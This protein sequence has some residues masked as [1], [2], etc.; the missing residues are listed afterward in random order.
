MPG[1]F[2]SS[3]VIRKWSNH[4]LVEIGWMDIGLRLQCVNTFMDNLDFSDTAKAN[5]TGMPLLCR[6]EVKIILKLHPF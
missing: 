1:V 6:K 2:S 3:C 4:V 5:F